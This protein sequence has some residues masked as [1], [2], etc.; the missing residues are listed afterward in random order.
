MKSEIARDSPQRFAAVFACSSPFG[1]PPS[2]LLLLHRCYDSAG[3]LRHV[4]FPPFQ[5]THR[6]SLFVVRLLNNFDWQDSADYTAPRRAEPSRAARSFMRARRSGF[7]V[8]E[9]GG[10][11]RPIKLNDLSE[12]SFTSHRGSDAHATEGSRPSVRP[13]VRIFDAVRTRL[14]GLIHVAG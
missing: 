8:L 4:L 7:N 2:C 12:K 5:H 10:R 11:P 6:T 13:P 9:D 3:S 1:D 14:Y